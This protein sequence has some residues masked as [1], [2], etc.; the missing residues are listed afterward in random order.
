MAYLFNVT[1][2]KTEDINVFVEVTSVHPDQNVFY[3]DPNFA[4]NLFKRFT[5]EYDSMNRLKPKYLLGHFFSPY[6]DVNKVPNKV[7]DILKS[8]TIYP[9]DNKENDDSRF[10][11]VYKV[12]FV[13]TRYQEGIKDGI[14]AFISDFGTIKYMPEQG[15]FNEY[16]TD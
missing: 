10:S 15:V 7:T 3:S 2:L 9:N 14:S 6:G 4:L 1:I 8:Y 11:V 5:C 12:A 13:E 16:F